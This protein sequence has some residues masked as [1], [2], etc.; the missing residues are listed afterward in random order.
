MSEVKYQPAP[1]GEGWRVIVTGSDRNIRITEHEGVTLANG[2]PR[3]YH[4]EKLVD[5]LQLMLDLKS[6][7]TTPAKVIGRGY[8]SRGKAL[9][10]EWIQGGI[11]SARESIAVLEGLGLKS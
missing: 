6:G 8:G 11:D 5:Y 4:R 10:T 7:K 3:D 9:A 1:C 2:L